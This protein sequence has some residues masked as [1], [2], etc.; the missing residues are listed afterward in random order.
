[1][2]LKEIEIHKIRLGTCNT[3]LIEFGESCILVDGGNRNQFSKFID[4]LEKL[5]IASTRIKLIIVTH[6][7]FDHVGSLADIKRLCR[8]PV[9]VHKTERPLLESGK[10][11][12]PPG[13]TPIGRLLSTVG[14]FFQRSERI[15]FEP[16]RADVP[17][18][19]LL[20]LKNY[21]FPAL[22]MHT[23][24]HT[25]GSIS[26]LLENGEAVVGDLVMNYLPLGRGPV[27]PLFAEDVSLVLKSWKKLIEA[28]MERLYPGH[29]KSLAVEGLIREHERRVGRKR[30]EDSAGE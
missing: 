28:G 25:S 19:D 6:V 17:V 5:K 16:V 12:V 18:D 21:G 14:I 10:V 27:F 7:H 11:V 30:R 23:P 15:G 1:M 8:C 26:L 9:L 2:P 29:G 20:D 13:T 3:Y 22:L 4:H 24:G